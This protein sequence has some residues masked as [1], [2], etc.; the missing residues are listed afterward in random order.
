MLCRC[1]RYTG[2]QVETLHYN[3]SSLLEI[4]STPAH[5]VFLIWHGKSNQTCSHNFICRTKQ[6]SSLATQPGIF[7]NSVSS[8][9]SG[10]PTPSTARTHTPNYS[11]FPPRVVLL[12]TNT[13]Q[14]CWQSIWSQLS[15]SVS[16]LTYCSITES[17][18]FQQKVCSLSAPGEQ[19]LSPDWSFW[20]FFL[21]SS[22][23]PEK[24]NF[25]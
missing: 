16:H 25:S 23:M 5:L 19:M 14:G 15:V 22:K 12:G 10:T 11:C 2:K 3:L 24:N 8:S 20:G 17:K 18:M 13:I 6:Y 7:L 21:W 1:M 9:E 4:W